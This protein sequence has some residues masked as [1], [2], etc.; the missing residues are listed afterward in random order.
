MKKDQKAIKDEISFLCRVK[1]YSKAK[2][3]KDDNIDVDIGWLGV[4]IDKAV[5]LQDELKKYFE[6]SSIKKRLVDVGV[7][8]STEEYISSER[9]NG[10][11]INVGCMKHSVENGCIFEKVVI[12][13]SSFDRESMIFQYAKDVQL[14]SPVYFGCLFDEGIGSLYYSHVESVDFENRDQKISSR[15]FLAENLWFNNLEVDRNLKKYA[16]KCK[17]DAFLSS[18]ERRKSLF[19]LTDPKKIPYGFL[20]GAINKL[21]SSPVKVFH[22]DF[23][24]GNIIKSPGRAYLIDWD[25]WSISKIGAGA[26]F[27]YSDMERL[28]FFDRILEKNIEEKF[29]FFWLK[30]FCIYNAFFW[31]GKG[32]DLEA[33]LYLQKLYSL[34][35]KSGWV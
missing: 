7:L 13:K 34:S 28:G 35:N 2:K 17:F 23:C 3:I 24:N 4:A 1:D 10:G 12:R 9:V 22:G 5:L 33:S 30:N 8:N 25:K 27:N 16:V 29:L 31:S 15:F 14:G 18:E 11:L 26:P 21:K 19:L 6:V 32:K 20:V